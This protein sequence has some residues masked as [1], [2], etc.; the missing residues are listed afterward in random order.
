MPELFTT[1]SFD[2][3]KV[4]AVAITAT[5]D[6]A[7]QTVVTMTTGVLPVGTYNIGYSFQ[8]THSAKNQPMYFKLDG[9]YADANYFSNTAG[10]SDELNK[11][12]AYFYPKEHAG[13]SIIISLLMYKPVGGATIDFADVVVHRVK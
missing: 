8:V 3:E 13:G 11:N 7:P 2:T 4:S 1:L 12:R 5:S 9:T 6:A 10:D